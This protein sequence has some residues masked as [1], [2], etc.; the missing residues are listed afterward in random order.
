MFIKK[1]LVNCYFKAMYFAQI[2]FGVPKTK[3]YFKSS[4][5]KAFLVGTPEHDNLG[6]HAI[7]LAERQFISKF[8]PE[9]EI[10]EISVESW[11]KYKVNLLTKTK[12]EDIF[13]LT[14]GGNM[15]NV[16]LLDEKARRFVISHFKDNK[17]VV[18]P[19]TISFTKDEKGAKELE[20]TKKIYNSHKRLLVCAREDR[21]YAMMSEYFTNCKVYLCPDMVLS[22]KLN[23]SKKPDEKRIGLCLRKDIESALSV[24][25]RDRITR[26]AGKDYEIT[27]FNT[28]LTH[29]IS[30]TEREKEIQKLLEEI[31]KNS[32][33]ITDRLHGVIFSIITGTPCIAYSGT[34]HKI[35]ATKKWVDDSSALTVIGTSDDLAEVISRV[36]ATAKP[37]DVSVF[38]DYYKR[39]ADIIGE[40]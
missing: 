1:V 14:G 2:L 3:Q 27:C 15:G 25:D 16:Y 33:V 7:A 38:K 13:F 36:K 21:S 37:F 8:F 29:G 12:A 24:E 39:M 32:L 35:P 40:L 19:Q 20:K 28:C 17:I 18:F 11:R 10:V 23:I 26:I 4:K 22:L 5:K 9:Y 6:D 30:E 34:S 31:S